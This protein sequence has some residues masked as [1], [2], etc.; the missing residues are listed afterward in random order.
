MSFGTLYS[1]EKFQV[2]TPTPLPPPSEESKTG[3]T[4]RN[5]SLQGAASQEQLW[6]SLGT[7]AMT[8]MVLMLDYIGIMSNI[9]HA[10]FSSWSLK[11]LENMIR[12]LEAGYHHARCF[13]AN[14]DLRKKLWKKGFMRFGDN[15]Q[16]LPHL[17]E[18]ET[19]S[20]AQ[21]LIVA[22]RLYT[23]AP[24][25]HPDATTRSNLAEPL[26]F[27]YCDFFFTSHNANTPWSVVFTIGCARW[28]MRR[29]LTWMS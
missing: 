1:R 27:R 15:S 7:S 29:T 8:A 12:C 6:S 5:G 2:A 22:F 14:T 10:Q 3:R 17:V 18:Q 21:I 23:Q 16:R 4:K 13:N 19:S 28:R 11:N 26:L 24:D 25:S 20:L 9:I